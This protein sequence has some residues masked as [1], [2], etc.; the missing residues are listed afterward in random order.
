MVANFQKREDWNDA[1]EALL[2]KWPK[3][4]KAHEFVFTS[5]LKAGK[6]S[7][8]MWDDSAIPIPNGAEII[9]DHR[10]EDLEK[11]FKKMENQIAE[12]TSIDYEERGQIVLKDIT[13]GQAKKEI[14]EYFS[15]HHGEI[16]DAADIQEA[17][18]IDISM[19]IEILDDLECEGKIKTR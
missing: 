18:N 5:G 16:I 4:G 19:A 14:K 8:P 6:Y 17:L 15:K 3:T 9:Y 1:N 10:I 13:Y 2:A 12:L 7:E 11:R